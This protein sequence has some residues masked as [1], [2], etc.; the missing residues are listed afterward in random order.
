MPWIASRITVRLKTFGI[1]D[2]ECTDKATGETTKERHCFITSLENDPKRILRF[3][4]KHWGIEIGL[5]W[6]LDV[7]F[8]EDDD[9]KRMNGAQNYSLLNK[10]ALKILK[11]HQ[12]RD[13]KASV[14]RKRLMAAWDE[15]YLNSL[16]NAFVLGF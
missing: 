11:C 12:H 4:K 6:Q 10:M 2:I 7:T 8:N 15:N 5:H 13:K 16:L 3:K 14:K 1:I 9:R